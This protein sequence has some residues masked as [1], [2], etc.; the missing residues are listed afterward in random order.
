MSCT[1][2]HHEQ[3]VIWVATNPSCN[4]IGKMGKFNS[5]K[6]SEFSI[7]YKEQFFFPTTICSLALPQNSLL[8]R[9]TLRWEDAKNEISADIH[10]WETQVKGLLQS[11]LQPSTH[12][13]LKK[14]QT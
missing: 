9:L 6:A 11:Q 7:T 8:P 12:K 14:P 3:L 4:A 5:L 1:Q 2:K 10:D 13:H